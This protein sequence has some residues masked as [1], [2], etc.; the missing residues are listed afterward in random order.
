MISLE[1]VEKVVRDVVEIGNIRTARLQ[2]DGTNPEGRTVG[3]RCVRFSCGFERGR[4]MF[5]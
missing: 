4:L 1:V 2:N 5:L 3:C